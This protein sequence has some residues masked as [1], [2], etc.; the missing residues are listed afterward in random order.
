MQELLG[1]TGL[2]KF[3]VG[4]SEMVLDLVGS[5]TAYKT[6]ASKLRTK[7]NGTMVLRPIDEIVNGERSVYSPNTSARALVG[8]APERLKSGVRNR[9]LDTRSKR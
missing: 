9:T 8:N 2:R 4:E 1:I 6:L 3:D 5:Q 7:N